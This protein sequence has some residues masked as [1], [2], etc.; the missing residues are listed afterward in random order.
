MQTLY[1]Q[2]ERRIPKRD[3]IVDLAAY[4][5]RL[6]REAQPEEECSLPA[7]ARAPRARRRRT[8]GLDVLASLSVVVMTLA[9]TVRVLFL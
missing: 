4:R 1:I 8:L 9:F 7:P 3:N 5:R 2:T 6:E